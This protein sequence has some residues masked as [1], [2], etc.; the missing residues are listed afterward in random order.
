MKWI[1]INHRQL[2]GLR[3]LGIVAEKTIL[4]VTATVSS[5]PP[6]VTTSATRESE[7]ICRQRCKELNIISQKTVHSENTSLDCNKDDISISDD[8]LQDDIPNVDDDLQDDN[9]ADT[10]SDTD[11][12]P[13]SAKMTMTANLITVVI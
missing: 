1:N 5:P 6:T 4:T 9:Y 12:I 13:S 10:G 2:S 11:C 7:E 8:S 3:Q